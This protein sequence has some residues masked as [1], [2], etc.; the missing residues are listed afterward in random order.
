VDKI[1]TGEKTT[2]WRM[3][4]DKNLT[5]G[6]QLEFLETET[7][8]KFAEAEITDIKEKKLEEVEEKDFS[9]HESYKNREEML[10]IYKKYYGDSVNIETSIKI[11]SFK[12]LK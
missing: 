3:F 11:I 2:T 4:D 12:L 7:L 6:D 9:G 10:A 1:L 8:E 5:V